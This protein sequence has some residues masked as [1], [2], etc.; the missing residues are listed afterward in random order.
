M[1]SQLG[2]L[3]L[4][5]Q[6]LRHN[7]ATSPLMIQRQPPRMIDAAEVKFINNTSKIAGNASEMPVPYAQWKRVHH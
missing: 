6:R 3:V 5:L 1:M 4:I 7:R 2:R